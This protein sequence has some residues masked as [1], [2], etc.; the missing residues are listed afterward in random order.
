MIHATNLYFDEQK[1]REGSNVSR[2]NTSTSMKTKK[3]PS[4]TA[5]NE[6][7]LYLSKY[8]EPDVQYTSSTNRNNNNNNGNSRYNSNSFIQGDTT[9]SDIDRYR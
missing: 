9:D 5:I 8:E 6:L 3:K 4:Y 1:K 2:F 7:D